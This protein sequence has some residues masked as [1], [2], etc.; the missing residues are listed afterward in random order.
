MCYDI[1][2][3]IDN[4]FIDKFIATVDYPN[5]YRYGC[6]KSHCVFLVLGLKYITYSI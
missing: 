4:K 5:G 3:T 2:I 1:N 6:I